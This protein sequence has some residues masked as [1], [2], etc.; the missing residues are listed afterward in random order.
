MLEK[1]ISDFREETLGQQDRDLKDKI[2]KMGI[3][4]QEVNFD[5]KSKTTP[6]VAFSRYS[7]P[8]QRHFAAVLRHG[9]RGDMVEGFEYSNKVDPPIT[10][11]GVK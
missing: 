6:S 5:G 8:S 3:K 2:L 7:M 1:D 9:E 11:L 10:P 4:H